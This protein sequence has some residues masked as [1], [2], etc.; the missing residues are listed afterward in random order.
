MKTI[1][2]AKNL[3]LLICLISG[4]SVNTDAQNLWEKYYD[5]PVLSGV[6]GS[7]YPLATNPDVIYEQDTF[8]MWFRGYVGV[9]ENMQI[10]YAWSLNGWDWNEDSL[11]VIQVGSP[12][13]WDRYK[14]VGNVI[15]MND[16]LKMWYIGT[17]DFYVYKTG[18]AWA[19]NDRNWH[20][21]PNP[22]VVPGP[23]GSWDENQ[24]C[25]GAVT[26]EGNMYHMYYL[27]RDN[28]GIEGIGHA[29]SYN[30]ILWTK[31]AGNPI[32]VPGE[33]NSFYERRLIP[34]DILLADGMVYLY[35]VGYALDFTVRIGLVVTEIGDW[36]NLQFGNFGQPVLDVGPE[37]SWD[38]RRV[39]LPSVLENDDSLYMWYEGKMQFIDNNSIGLATDF[40]ILP[41]STCLPSGVLFS[42]QSEIDSFQINYP[43]CTEIEGSVDINGNDITDLSG[44]DTLNSIGGDLIINGNDSLQYLSGLANLNAIGG[45]LFIGSNEILPDLSGLESLETIGGDLSIVEN[46][47]LTSLYGIENIEATSIDNLHIYD[48]PLL[49][50]CHVLSIC[51]Y[52]DHPD[53]EFTIE[54]NANGCNDSTEIIDQCYESINEF[55]I[56]GGISL[57]PNPSSDMVLIKYS[58]IEESRITI[59]MYDLTGLKVLHV[60]EKNERKGEHQRLV[61]LGSLP[62]GMYLVVMQTGKGKVVE[63][64]VKL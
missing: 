53:A 30:G 40:E 14:S 2:K 58:L 43:Y 41:P 3:I 9:G 13:D 50:T 54:N 21:L 12:G 42:T 35:V 26:H 32:L 7:W 57:T 44:L 49:S 23:P 20:T 15:K 61:D 31:Y 60:L 47:A 16:T 17:E 62:P 33:P 11:P 27:G 55:K 34:S 36:T 10:G 1:T 63:K 46:T 22:V 24:V 51:D 4:I 19:L 64:I 28:N 6:H 48:N 39:T 29:W 8:K 59:D 25:G 38:E 37:G 52:L 56:L 5:N 45:D 18:Y